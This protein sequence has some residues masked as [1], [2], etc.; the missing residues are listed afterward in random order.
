VLVANFDADAQAD[1][2][3]LAAELRRGVDG[4]TLA[5]EVYPDVDKLGKQ[6]KYAAERGIPFVALSVV[7]GDKPTDADLA[8]AVAAG[9]ASAVLNKAVFASPGTLDIPEWALAGFGKIVA[10]KAENNVPKLTAYRAKAKA[11]AAGRTRGAVKLADVW[12]GTKGKDSDVFGASVVDLLTSGPDPKRFLTIV[13]G[14]QKSDQNPS[15]TIEGILTVLDLPADKL[16]AE[17]KAF[18]TK[19]K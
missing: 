16:D 11:L 10:L 5:V 8:S 7:V 15:R 14:F 2:L 9:T 12:S 19:A 1:T 18:V 13:H 17:W 4:T 6:F 3:A